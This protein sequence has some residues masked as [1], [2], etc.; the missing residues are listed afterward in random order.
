MHDLLEATV[1]AAATTSLVEGTVTLPTG[2]DIVIPAMMYIYCFFLSFLHRTARKHNHNHDH[3]H[4]HTKFGFQ[5]ETRE[6]ETKEV[7]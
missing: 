5:K 7:R 1:A 2:T 3:T 6:E 4:T